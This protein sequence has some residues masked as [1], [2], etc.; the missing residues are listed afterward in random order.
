MLILAINPGSTS[1]EF[2]VFEEDKSIVSKKIEH[3]MD[4]LKPPILEQFKIRMDYIMN[5][6]SDYLRKINAVSSRG[7]ILHPMEGGVYEV[8]KSVVDDIR[9]GRVDA[10]HAANVGILI[11][12]DIKKRFSIP[13]YMVDPISTDELWQLARVSGLPDVPRSGRTHSLNVRAQARRRAEEIKRPLRNTTFIVV[14]IGGGLTVNLVKGGRICDVA[15][16]RQSGPFSPEAC[17]GLSTPDYTKLCFSGKYTEEE[18]IRFSYGE[19]GLK[20]WLGTSSIE[21]VEK[22]IRKGDRKAGYIFRAMAYSIAKSIG[23]LLVC[24]GKVDSV[25]L[26]GGG[27]KSKLL[28]SLISKYISP[29][30]TIVVY[31][32]SI[33]LKAIVE[34]TLRVLRGEERAKKYE[35]RDR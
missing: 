18:M 2:G 17:G 21:E 33:E 35:K 20:K 5:H 14:H 12:Y 3:S 23:G 10:Q 4:E 11:A 34:S 24:G 13:A 19:G 15:D 25:I 32:G 9:S 31:P 26:T 22:R 7:G 30:A 29:Y 8:N 1:T 16:A 28:V 27:S 6:T